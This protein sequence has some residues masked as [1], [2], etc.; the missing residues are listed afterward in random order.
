M[1]TTVEIYEITLPPHGVFRFTSAQDD[2]VYDGNTYTAITIERGERS[3]S[4]DIERKTSIKI[5]M[6]VEH[7]FAKLYALYPPLQDAECIIYQATLPLGSAEVTDPE[8][9]F[10]G[11]LLTYG[12]E[13]RTASFE[14]TPRIH[15]A[16]RQGPR[17]VYSS[18]CRHA[19]YDRGCK[20]L[21]ASYQESV[22]VEEVRP[23]V[24]ELVIF[25][26]FDIPGGYYQG[27]F[28]RVT[29]ESDPILILK[30][31]L[32]SNDPP[33][34][35][36]IT[37]TRWSAELTAEPSTIL[38]APG[39]DYSRQTCIDRFDNLDNFGGFDSLTAI[40]RSP[41]FDGWNR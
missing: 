19:L 18:L 23:D 7:P 22:T 32:S 31:G 37:L 39:C 36:T 35:T 4:A 2:L 10:R 11:V 33:Y 24:R 17:G 41:F 25:A 5:S 28:I 34:R 6:P 30:Q 14:V 21:L 9:V 16:N 13:G 38:A 40:D 3:N 29:A 20:V 12:S 15:A 26:P 27:G 8:P 1:N